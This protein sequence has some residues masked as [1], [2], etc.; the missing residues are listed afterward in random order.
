[1]RAT[2]KMEKDKERLPINGNRV[3]DTLVCGETIKWRVRPNS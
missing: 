2:S 3:K 1:M